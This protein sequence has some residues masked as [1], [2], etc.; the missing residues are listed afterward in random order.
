MSE[1]TQ[2]THVSRHA[3][4]VALLVNRGWADRWSHIVTLC[5]SFL[6]LESFSREAPSEKI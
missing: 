5:S 6:C 3:D 1:L 2:K 4:K